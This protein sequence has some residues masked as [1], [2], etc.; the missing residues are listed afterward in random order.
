M[1]GLK[2]INVKSCMHYFFDDMINIKNLDSDK[3]KIDEES[4][5]NI[6]IY[7]IGYLTVKKLS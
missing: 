1:N 6:F 3:I 2:E 4:Y 5:K 7:N